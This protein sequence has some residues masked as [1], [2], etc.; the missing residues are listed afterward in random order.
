MIAACRGSAL[1]LASCRP[2]FAVSAQS[3]PP[4]TLVVLREIDADNYDPAQAPPPA[5]AG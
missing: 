1:T 5:S 3:A 4:N 2:K